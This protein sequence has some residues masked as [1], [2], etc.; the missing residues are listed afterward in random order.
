MLT[1]NS[2]PDPSSSQ[3]QS[4]ASAA[5]E[6]NLGLVHKAVAS[7]NVP[8]VF[9]QDAF[10]EA[11]LAFLEHFPDYDSGRGAL[12][13]FL[14]PHLRGAVLHFL[15][16][17]ARFPV[18]TNDDRQLDSAALSVPK[19][20]GLAL[21]PVPDE[22]AITFEVVRVLKKADEADR[23][24]AFEMYWQGTSLSEI[25]RRG[26]ISRQSVYIRKKRLDA[27]MRVRLASDS[28]AA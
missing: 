26:G 6:S 28:H 22:P 3:I 19:R 14:W 24:L 20:N 11:A 4:A 16:S 21:V 5:L 8:D 9:K 12:S 13:T 1:D 23:T 27:Q 15:R 2:S 10:Q 7:V 25:A 18:T 17:E